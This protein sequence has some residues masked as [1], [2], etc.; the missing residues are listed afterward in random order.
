M[1][2][3][4]PEEIIQFTELIEQEIR[5]LR[6][7][8]KLLEAGKIKHEEVHARIAIYSQK[9]KTANRPLKTLQKKINEKEKGEMKNGTEKT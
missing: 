6:K 9:A 7:L 3:L 1:K 8:L 4:K 2:E 5:E